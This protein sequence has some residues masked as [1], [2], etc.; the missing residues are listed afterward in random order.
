[1]IDKLRA[2]CIALLKSAP[3]H[4]TNEHWPELDE[5]VKAL[6]EPEISEP[7]GR[8]GLA[9]D[10]RI[11]SAKEFCE[12]KPESHMTKD[13]ALDMALNLIEVYC[14]ECMHG[15]PKRQHVKRLRQALAEP[16]TMTVTEL[17]KRINRGE[18][19]KLAE[20]SQKIK[21][22]RELLDNLLAAQK[23]VLDHFWGDHD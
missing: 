14:P 21:T 20:P 17:A 19:W 10:F 7:N 2:A 3:D 5:I 15:E 22:R 18:K 9:K 16:D 23:E 4:I 12:F 11:F 1:M 8:V 6:V 13:E